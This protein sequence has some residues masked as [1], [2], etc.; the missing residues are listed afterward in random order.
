MY[1]FKVVT[2][3][4]KKKV[5]EEKSHFPA[6]QEGPRLISICLKPMSQRETVTG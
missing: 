2:I 5:N 6:N 4:E 1:Y 3:F